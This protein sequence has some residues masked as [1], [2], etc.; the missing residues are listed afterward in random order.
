MRKGV[1]EPP[2]KSLHQSSFVW[3]SNSKTSSKIFPYDTVSTL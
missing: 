3:V 1:N 2:I